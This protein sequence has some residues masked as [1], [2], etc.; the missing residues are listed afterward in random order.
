MD[1]NYIGNVCDCQTVVCYAWLI[2]CF[3]IVLGRVGVTMMCVCVCV[4]DGMCLLCKVWDCIL[5]LYACESVW[6]ARNGNST[7]NP[8]LFYFLTETHMVDKQNQKQ[9]KQNK[10]NQSTNNVN[11]IFKSQK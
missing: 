1:A 8:P 9:A 4:C 5:I 11:V 6:Y 3:W 10:K 7:C 2:D